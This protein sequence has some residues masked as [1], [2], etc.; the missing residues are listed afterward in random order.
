MVIVT[1]CTM[2]Q[3]RAL[4]E[5]LVVRKAGIASSLQVLVGQHAVLIRIAGE[6]G[7]MH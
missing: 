5:P 6:L 7:G 4:G 1:A 3:L 2:E